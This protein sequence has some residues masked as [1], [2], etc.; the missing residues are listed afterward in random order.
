MSDELT[1]AEKHPLGPQKEM[2]ELL[3][4]TAAESRKRRFVQIAA[5]QSTAHQNPITL[6]GLSNDGT[7][8]MLPAGRLQWEPLPSAPEQDHVE[9][10]IVQN[11][12]VAMTY[13]SRKAG[14]GARLKIE[15]AALV[16]KVGEDGR[17]T[18][19]SGTLHVVGYTVNH[20]GERKEISRDHA[21]NWLKVNAPQSNKSP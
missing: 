17:K 1:P 9:F 11:D 21:E 14:D 7:V 13:D 4:Q 19:P 20:L 18:F 10:D 2:L 15:V 16:A 3:A 5:A 12:T 8:W 6:Y